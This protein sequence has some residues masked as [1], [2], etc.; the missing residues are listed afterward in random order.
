MVRAGDASEQRLV[1]E[2]CRGLNMRPRLRRS[3]V[4]HA[5]IEGGML[6]SIMPARA[7]YIR[8]IYHAS[9]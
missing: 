2:L 5:L 4:D 6:G 7:C 1:P 3:V 8:C 9:D